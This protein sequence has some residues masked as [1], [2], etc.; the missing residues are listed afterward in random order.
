MAHS[1]RRLTPLAMLARIVARALR[2]LI[3]T[4]VTL[5]PELL[6]RWPELGT[7]H[8][9]RGGLPPRIGGWCLGTSTVA[10]ITLYRTIWLSPRTSLHPELLLHE[11]RHVQQFASSATFPLQYALESARRGYHRNRFETDAIAYAAHRLHTP[12]GPSTK[13]V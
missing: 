7:A 2:P 6:E 1:A 4:R 11:L 8:W 13:D 10:A 5:P 9:R 12:L 3:G